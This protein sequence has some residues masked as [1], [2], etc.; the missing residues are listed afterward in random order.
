MSIYLIVIIDE[1]VEYIYLEER[2]VLTEERFLSEKK[3]LTE[4]SE[5]LE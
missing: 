3:Y 4:I 2:R 5:K 1:F